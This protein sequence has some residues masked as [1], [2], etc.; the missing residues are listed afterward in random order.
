M[1]SKVHTHNYLKQFE[2]GA[3][4]NEDSIDYY[5]ARFE[6]EAADYLKGTTSNDVGAVIIYYRDGVEVAYFD[7][8]NLV[9][10]VLA[11]GGT[12][13]SFMPS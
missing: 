8:E 2:M 4:G 5:I 12:E 6:A 13:A 10:S 7:Y 1:A 11:L 3:H 9:G